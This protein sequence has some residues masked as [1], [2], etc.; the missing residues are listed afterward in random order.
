M[1]IIKYFERQLEKVRE[2]T[3]RRKSA[4]TLL[5]ELNALKGLN[6][7]ERRAA[8]QKNLCGIL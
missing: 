7:E 8:N 5:K 1:T 6:V 2:Q 4:Q 3:G